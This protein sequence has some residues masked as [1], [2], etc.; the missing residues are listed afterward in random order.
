MT[1]NLEGS[2][3]ADIEL[4]VGKELGASAAVSDQVLALYIPN[5]D[6]E[7]RELGTQ[8]KWVLEAADLLARIGGGVTIM[9]PAEGGW[10]DEQN[11]RI[12]W[13]KPVVVYSYIKPTHF[14]GN[15]RRLREFLHRLGRE[16][17]Q[18]EVVVELDG[19]FY[20]ITDYANQQGDNS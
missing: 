18:G 20:R 2:E 6:R 14:L 7:G 5:K 12:V 10:F 4:D 11:D 17:N 1:E 8:R 13:E 15:L 9:P 16:T 3:R 19:V